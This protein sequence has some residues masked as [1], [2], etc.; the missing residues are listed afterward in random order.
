MKEALD[1]IE[2]LLFGRV[3]SCK[4][5][6]GRIKREQMGRSELRRYKGR[7]KRAGQGPPLHNRCNARVQKLF[8]GAGIATAAFAA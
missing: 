2:G 3:I 7:K 4:V 5:K 6:I 1:W 8:V